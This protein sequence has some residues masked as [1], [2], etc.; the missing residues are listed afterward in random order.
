M[1]HSEQFGRSFNLHAADVGDNLPDLL[2]GHAD[3]LAVGSVGRHCSAGDSVA[4]YLKHLRVGVN[5][6]LLGPRQVGAAAA[7]TRSQPVAERA[8]DAELRL[9]RLC[10]LGIVGVGIAFVG[11][12]K[13][14]RRQD[15]QSNP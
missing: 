5:M 12:E 9:A 10:G 1:W 3:A 13:G 8:V 15:E 14:D 11:G 2:V 7:A 6:L 4:D